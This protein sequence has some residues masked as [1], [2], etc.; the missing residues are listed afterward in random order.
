M[1]GQGFP[2]VLVD[3]ATVE[4]NPR[5]GARWVYDAGMRLPQTE[6]GT[7]AVAMADGIVR[8]SFA[9]SHWRDSVAS[10]A[11]QLRALLDAADEG[12][13]AARYRTRKAVRELLH[14][15]GED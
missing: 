13:A 1:T 14:L 10:A 7:E 5:S 11:A 3:F 2:S 9:A 8:A 4:K 12:D 15:L 6:R